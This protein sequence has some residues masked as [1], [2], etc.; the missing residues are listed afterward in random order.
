LGWDEPRR[1]STRP[2]RLQRRIGSG[3]RAPGRRGTVHPP[4]RPA[5]APD[6]HGCERW[7]GRWHRYESRFALKD[8]AD[9]VDARSGCA[10]GR[11]LAGQERPGRS[12]IAVVP[13]LES[14]E[15]RVGELR[16]QGAPTPRD[17]RQVVRCPWMVIGLVGS[18]LGAL[19]IAVAPSIGVA[20]IGWCIAQLFQR[21]AGRPGGDAAGSGPGRS[22]WHGRPCQPRA[23]A[24]SRI[25]ATS[26]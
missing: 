1:S 6:S 5:A 25:W 13:R 17:Q 7:N 19:V 12:L 2:A 4:A 15:E 9:T 18:S 20:L 3:L 11:A 26:V 10:R 23:R 21:A 8:R 14:A 16:E 22:T 24:W